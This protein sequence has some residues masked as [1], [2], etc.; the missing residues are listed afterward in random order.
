[1]SWRTAVVSLVAACAPLAAA[2]GEFPHLRARAI[3]DARAAYADASRSWL[4]AGLGKTRYGSGDGEVLGRLSQ[5]TLLLE[6]DLSHA[7]RLRAQANVDAD[8]DP[9]SRQ[10]RLDLVEAYAQ[11]QP[12]VA[13]ALRLRARAGMFFPPIS[14]EHD[15]PGWTTTYTITPSAVN[16]WVG[17]EVRA[18][19]GELTL[20]VGRERNQLS[21][22]GGAFGGNDPA[23]TLL[24]WRGWALHDRQTG[25]PDRLPLAPLPSIGPARTFDQQPSWTQPVREVD[26]R[27]GYFAGGEARLFG[28]LRVRALRW[29]NRGDVTAFE[30]QQ[31]A[32]A[33]RMDAFGLSLELPGNVL[34]LA[35]HARG[36]SDMGRMPDGSAAVGVE[37]RATYVLLTAG[38]GRHRVSARWDTFEA[39]EDD[40][41]PAL[42]DN[43]E[44]GTAWTAAYLIRIG[45]RH[46]AALEV[47][48][49]ESTRPA[50]LDLGLPARERDTLVQASL[51]LMF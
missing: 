42:D 7:F 18:T 9:A 30:H 2:A 48:S 45:E 23:G 49:V 12:D 5:A 33:T 37:P 41:L 32:W 46:R 24:A 34:L 51:R 15:G 28:S 27:A 14:L 25:L 36:L 50:R 3:L 38:F 16:T 19:G 26:G 29:D 22:I 6:A 35:Q 39:G 44:D 11:F 4:D 10:T 20:G 1:M 8:P 43:R 13:A 31:Y 47:L 21:L 17:E 40:A